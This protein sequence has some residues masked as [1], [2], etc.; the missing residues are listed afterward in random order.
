MASDLLDGF[1]WVDQEEKP[2]GIVEVIPLTGISN[3][4]SYKVPDSLLDKVVIG[5][6]VQMPIRGRK[7]IGIVSALNV[8]IDFPVSKLKQIYK[9]VNELPV[10]TPELLD[11]ARWMGFYYNSGLESVFET[12]IPAAIR[13]GMDVKTLRFIRL[14][15]K[16]SEDEIKKLGRRSPRQVELYHYLLE[17]E[18]PV[19]RVKVLKELNI[20]PSVCDGMVKNN[21]IEETFE[22]D[23]RIAYSDGLEGDITLVSSEFELNEEQKNVADQNRKFIKHGGFQVNLIHGVT[24]AGKTEVY[25]DAMETALENGGGVLFLVPEVALAPQ[26]VER[27]RRRFQHKGEK[28][29]VWHSQLSHGERYDAWL[30][31]AKGESRVVVGARSA[32]FAPIKNL[33]LIIVDE[34]H[35]PAYKQEESPRYNGRDVAVYRASRAGALCL[36]GSATPSLESLYNVQTGKYAIG[37]LKNRV[38]D[39]QL[40]KMHIV[41]MKVELRKNNS[42]AVFSHLLIDGL[43][44]RIEKREQSILFL[45]RRGYS[46]SLICPDC[47]YVGNCDHCSVTLTYHKKLE[48]LR[49][50]LCGHTRKAPVRCPSCGSEKVRW[51]GTGTQKVEELVRKLIPNARVVRIDADTMSRKDLYRSILQDFKLG[52]IDILVG[53]QMIAKGLDFPNVTLV[54]IINADL[55][56]HVEDFRAAERTFQLLVQVAGRAGRGDKAGEVII[57][58]M[59][60]FADPLQFAKRQEFDEFFHAELEHRKEFDYPPFR[61]LI[62]HIFRSKSI[63]KLEFY[64]EEWTKRLE[65]NLPAG[66][67]IR[68]PAPAPVEKIKDE[69]RYHLWY[70]VKSVTRSLPTIA[71]LRKEF[72]LDPAISDLLDIDPMNM[73]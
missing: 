23:E 17:H 39:R 44:D 5:S 25:L 26:T 51:N 33:K 28:V 12:M 61:H 65:N 2:E 11:L 24:G 8:E 54:G 29:V 34:E 66:M 20:S 69:Y 70:F 16:L 1:E 18:K 3:S 58:T 63:E 56:L 21:L 73:S 35:E 38:D 57:Q 4:L 42:I 49:C 68:G 48:E 43:L 46:K 40:P 31:T 30:S 37:K 27:V 14:I 59:T 13:K 10:I 50:H 72:P 47:G 41:D 64:T 45:N 22:Q 55:S 32:A 7:E 36:L 53:T 67:E 60:P 62:R 15:K 6:L 19:P 52:K 71:N 9:L